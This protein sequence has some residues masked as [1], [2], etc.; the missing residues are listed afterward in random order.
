MNRLGHIKLF[1]EFEN[2]NFYALHFNNEE[3]DEFTRFLLKF[4]NDAEN[5]K[6][7]D[8][9]ISWLMSIGKS[10]AYERKFRPEKNA[11]AVPI[12]SCKLRLY[13][14]RISDQVL[15]LCNGGI[16]TNK[17]AQLC[18]NVGPLFEDANLLAKHIK[19]KITKKEI[20]VNGKI[21]SGNLI[22]SI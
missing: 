9:L 8:I 11:S 13:C 17:K 20:Q 14:F 2:I 15:I 18:P 5:K 10:Y 12:P 21:L 3:H 22:V 1:K 4:E 7:F 19:P 16:K 6:D